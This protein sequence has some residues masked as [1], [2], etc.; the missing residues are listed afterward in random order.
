MGTWLDTLKPDTTG[1]LK[2]GIWLIWRPLEG[3][4][5]PS[6]LS[7]INLHMWN[8]FTINSHSVTVYFNDLQSRMKISCPRCKT[9]DEDIHHFLYQK[10]HR[11]AYNNTKRQ[12]SQQ[13]GTCVLYQAVSSQPRKPH[14]IPQ[15]WQLPF[16]HGWN[17]A[18]GN[19]RTNSYRLAS[20]G[21][22][23]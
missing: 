2:Y 18:T 13:P 1:R 19:R 17:L 14:L 6:Y 12:P 22:L 4:L 21:F 11:L 8:S 3:I 15:Q 9:T 7:S 23:N 20:T 5:K 16:I 10:H